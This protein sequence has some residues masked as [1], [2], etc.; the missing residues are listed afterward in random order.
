MEKEKYRHI[1]ELEAI[2]DKQEDLVEK[3]NDLLDQLEE[4]RDGYNKL[5]EYYHSDQFL[6]E[7]IKSNIGEIPEDIKCGIL[8]EDSIYNLIGDNYYL[9]IRMIDLASKILKD[10]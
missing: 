10:H 2:Y 3:I 8:S 1:V 7:Y 5:K 9:A 6:D 4:S